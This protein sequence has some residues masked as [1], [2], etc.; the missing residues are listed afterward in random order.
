MV[1][2]FVT[3][4][5]EKRVV[6][7]SLVDVRVVALPGAVIVI[8]ASWV[9]VLVSVTVPSVIVANCVVVSVM[10]R[11]GG[12]TAGEE[13]VV[14]LGGRRPFPGGV[15]VIVLVTG[16]R[17]PSIGRVAV[18]V[19]VPRSGPGKVTVDSVVVVV[20]LVRVKVLVTTFLWR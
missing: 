16:L 15:T 13:T 6:G 3:I 18:G 19:S 7:I 11:A 12:V 8:M 17:L 4:S 14:V 2:T 20:V 9:V 10:V 5:V 1:F